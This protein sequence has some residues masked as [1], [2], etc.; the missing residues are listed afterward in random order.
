[1]GHKLSNHSFFNLV[2]TSKQLHFQWKYGNNPIKSTRVA[3]ATHFWRFQL[4]LQT[5]SK[6]GSGSYSYSY[7]S[8]SSSS[9]LSSTSSSVFSSSLSSSFLVS[10]SYE[11]FLVPLITIQI[12]YIFAAKKACIAVSLLSGAKNRSNLSCIEHILQYVFPKKPKYF[13]L[14]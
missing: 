13:Y 5:N 3:G 14:S 10:S 6:F 12:C 11:E 8:S 2:R 7:L 4:R 1:M 9:S